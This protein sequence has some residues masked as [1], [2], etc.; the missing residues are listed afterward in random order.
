MTSTDLFVSEAAGVRTLVLNRLERR[1]ALNTTLISALLHALRAADQDSAV[2]AIVLAANGPVFCA[3][4]DMRE[5]G[6]EA[7]DPAANEH[8]SEQLLAL[9][10]AFDKIE[11]P[12]VCAVTG[13]AIGAGAS[14]AIAADLTVMDAQTFL[15]WPETAHG[16]VPGGVI[17]HLQAR[18]SRKQ[19]FELLAL[20]ERLQANEALRIGLVNRVVAGSEV[21][22]TAAQL[23]SVLATRS[24]EVMR[25][26]KHVFVTTA[27]LPVR[28]ALRAGRD[29]AR[30]RQ[31]RG[32]NP[33]GQ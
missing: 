20:G 28:E 15:S 22:A 25:A 12:I 1:N 16:M 8:R 5:F 33:N 19:A 23:A 17:G 30:S 14:L 21:M 18:C 7:A 26:T 13:P 29:A 9:Q 32:N 11:V 2:G 10:L 27:G 6:S 3:G 4:A 24:R 31:E